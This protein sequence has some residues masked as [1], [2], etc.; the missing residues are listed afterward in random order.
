MF[1]PTWLSMSRLGLGLTLVRRI[2]ELHGGTVGAES[3]GRGEG[4]LAVRLPLMASAAARPRRG[5]R[6]RPA[7]AQ[8]R[9]GRTPTT[10]A[11]LHRLLEGEGSS[12]RAADGESGLRAILE[13]A[14]DVDVVDLG[15]PVA[16]GY[17]IAR[18][19]R[20]AGVPRT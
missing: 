6:R 5:R 16:D 14:P 15:L 11:T 9:R 3:R 7:L 20:S 19:V 8:H 18:R 13:T 12:V 10:R 2:V 1:C 4:R 17:E